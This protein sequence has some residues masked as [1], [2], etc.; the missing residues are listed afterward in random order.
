MAQLN[1]KIV[2][3]LHLLMASISRPEHLDLFE[4][5]IAH[6]IDFA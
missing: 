6:R 3:D 2:H 5:G 1:P 4:Q